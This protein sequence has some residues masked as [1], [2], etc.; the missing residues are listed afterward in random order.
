MAVGGAGPR[1]R[2]SGGTR[3]AAHRGDGPGRLGAELAGS[4]P[5]RRNSALPGSVAPA[6]EMDRWHHVPRAKPQHA[7][8][9]CRGV[10]SGRRGHRLGVVQPRQAAGRHRWWRE[11]RCVQR[12]WRR[13]VHLRRLSRRAQTCRVEAGGSDVRDLAAASGRD[14]RARGH[15]RRERRRRQAPSEFHPG[16]D[17]TLGQRQRGIAG[18][19]SRH[20]S[21]R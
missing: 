9:H 8:G 17:A 16:T 15:Q 2:R 21:Y 4:R 18:E 3:A 5:H 20:R 6:D 14:H 10:H 19:A 13:T 1:N 7:L 12:Q 11:R